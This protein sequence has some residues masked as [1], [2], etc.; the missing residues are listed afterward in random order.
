ME[1]LFHELGI[2]PKAV[3]IQAIGFLV[4]FLILKRY[5][6]GMVG[7]L[8]EARRREIA[9]RDR[10]LAE[11]HAEVERLK[12]EIQRRLAE[13]EA[14]ARTR[15]QQAIIEADQERNKILDD[16]R[17][18]ALHEIENATAEIQREK[19]RALLELRAQLA[20][21][22]ISVASKII[23]ENLDDERNRRL[24]DTIIQGITEA[25]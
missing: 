4:L 23:D 22:A 19:E 18:R 17:L 1:G 13:I 11:D 24:T 21:L 15:I 14:E 2:D 9:E 3:I 10:K 12:A 5:V 8:L 25:N 7:G 16:A 20:D 6:F